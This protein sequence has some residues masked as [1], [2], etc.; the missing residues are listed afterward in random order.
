MSEFEEVLSVLM[1]WHVPMKQE[2]VAFIFDVD[3]S[4][5]SCK[6][7]KWGLKLQRM[8]RMG[9]NLDLDLTFDFMS[10]DN[11]V[12]FG[13]EHYST[14]NEKD[15]FECYIDES[16]LTKYKDGGSLETVSPLVD[17]KD[18][19]TNSVWGMGTLWSEHNYVFQKE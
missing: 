3:Q 11:C 2:L 19:S 5:I 10:A 6:V 8:G 7:T 13:I 12:K 16:R 17:G 15:K 1:V 14:A 4:T 9:S 18:I